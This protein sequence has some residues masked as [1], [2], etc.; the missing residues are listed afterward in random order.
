MPD[1]GNMKNASP[2]KRKSSDMGEDLGPASK[3]GKTSTNPI[4]QEPR[5]TNSIALPDPGEASTAT[6]QKTGASKLDDPKRITRS[7]NLLNCNVNE[8]TAAIYWIC[9]SKVLKKVAQCVGLICTDVVFRVHKDCL[10]VSGMDKARSCVAE[11]KLEASMRV[12]HR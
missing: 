8:Q 11:C 3:R 2:E 10:Y 12:F 9:E 6:G 7:L 1:V 4:K 5:D